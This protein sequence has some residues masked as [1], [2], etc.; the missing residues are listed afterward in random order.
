MAAADP[1]TSA[2]CSP[3]SLSCPSV[4]QP[5]GKGKALAEGDWW[6][7]RKRGGIPLP[8][9]TLAGPVELLLQRA[10]PLTAYLPHAADVGEARRIV[11]TPGAIATIRGLKSLSLRYT[12]HRLNSLF[13]THHGGMQLST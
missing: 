6:Q 9:I 2:T 13:L 1:H 10:H 11:L 8:D 5:Q 7:L 3:A 4:L 12:P